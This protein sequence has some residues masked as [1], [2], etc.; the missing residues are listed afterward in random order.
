[1]DVTDQ[2]LVIRTWCPFGQPP[3]HLIELDLATVGWRCLGKCGRGD[4]FHFE[5][6]RTEIQHLRDCINRV[7]ATIALNNQPV[8][9]SSPDEPEEAE[10]E[11]TTI[12]RVEARRVL[13]LIR[14]HPGSSRRWLQQVAHIPA[15]RF[16]RVTYWLEQEKL[17]TFTEEMSTGG[18]PRRTYF[19]CHP[20]GRPV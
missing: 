5:A 15:V 11:L 3:P 6:K 14:S 1:M 9:N 13:G 4:I 8:R 19:P 17:V 16:N 18:R 10:S 12:E 7:W 2:C 20:D